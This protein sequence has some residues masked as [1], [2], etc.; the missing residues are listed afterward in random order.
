MHKETGKYLDQGCRLERFFDIF[1]LVFAFG[2]FTFF[3]SY[4]SSFKAL[5]E[6]EVFF[7]QERIGKDGKVFRLK[8]ATMSKIVLTLGLEL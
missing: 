4:C 2:T 6:G 7:L 1:L 8:F 5:G 3:S